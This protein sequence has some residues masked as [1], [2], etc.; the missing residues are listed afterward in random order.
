MFGGKPV[1]VQM[2]GGGN[3]TLTLVQP[4]QGVTPV[5]KIVRIPSTSAVTAPT[6]TEQPK[7]M[8]VQRQKQPSATIGEPRIVHVVFSKTVV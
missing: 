4:Q 2:T 3:K 6:T 8:V 5:G 7:L 1:T